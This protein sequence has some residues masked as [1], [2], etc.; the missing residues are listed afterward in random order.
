VVTVRRADDL[1]PVGADP[2]AWLAGFVL[3]LV[4]SPLALAALVAGHGLLRWSRSR[5]WMLAAG[6]AGVGLV[7]VLLGGGPAA[8]LVSHFAGP[9]TLIHDWRLP[10]AGEAG[11]I[12]AR[13]APLAVPLG[14]LAAGL[15]ELGRPAHELDPGTRAKRT[16]DRERRRTRAKRLADVPRVPAGGGVPPMAVSITGDLDDWRTGGLVTP[17]A[18]VRRLP[19]VVLGMPGFG[20]TTLLERQTFMAAATGEPCQVFDGKGTDDKLAERLIAAYLAGKSDARVGLYPQ[21]AMD[22]WR[23]GPQAVLNRLLA[24]IDY[25][26]P[27]EFHGDR[28]AMALR[29]ALFAPGR[30]EVRSSR[31]LINR[32][33]RETLRSYYPADT[34]DPEQYTAERKLIDDCWQGGD[35]TLRLRALLAALAS[36]FHEGVGGDATAYARSPLS[37]ENA[38]V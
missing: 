17:P 21:V 25:H 33:N 12:L 1:R 31:E 11:A 3:L 8:V 13:Q 24:C 27:A 22:G 35:P 9:A 14:M 18:E 5:P 32:L 4:F 2:G 7:V 36:A 28:L 15:V 6:A 23:G 29:L 34:A 30:P 37:R 19:R 20:K 38:A 26:G 16:R 10:G